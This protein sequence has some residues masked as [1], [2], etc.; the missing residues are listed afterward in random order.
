M[1]KSI[2]LVLFDG[3][4]DG[5]I[6]VTDT[7]WNAGVLYS[8][9]R[10]NVQ[11]ILDYKECKYF[12][13][14]LL[15]SDNKVYVGQAKDLSNRINNHII[16]KDW[17]TRVIV[18][19]TSNNSFNS[20]H[21]D[22]IEY[23]LIERSG[24]SIDYD[25]ENKRKGNDSNINEHDRILLDGYIKEA[26]DLLGIIGVNVFNINGNIGKAKHTIETIKNES[27][28][29]KL[30]KNKKEVVNYLRQ[31]GIILLDNF[32]YS[33][34]QEKKDLF[35]IN[36]SIEA[37]TKDWNIVLNNQIKS[38]IIVLFIPANKFNIAGKGERGIKVRNDRKHIIDLEI[39][40]ETLRIVG[41]DEDLNQFIVKKIK[42]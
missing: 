20:A 21:I 27:D 12:G 8:A 2:Q 34:R 1:E 9:P 14:Y 15:L 23:Q 42:Y 35:W 37:L 31:N 5:I 16:G 22:Y 11:K 25:C 24:K 7:S 32:N 17:W 3:N 38:E 18:L 28:E 33:K 4:L 41:S 13:V 36:P 40:S 26:I 39:N 19:T 29:S 10:E 30:L 6:K